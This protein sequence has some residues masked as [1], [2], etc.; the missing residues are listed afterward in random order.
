MMNMQKGFAIICFALLLLQCG[1][2]KQKNHTALR[3]PA[4][5]EQNS[6][7]LL[8]T[9][10]KEPNDGYSWRYRSDNYPKQSI[11]TIDKSVLLSTA[12]RMVRDRHLDIFLMFYS[13]DVFKMGS[14]DA[15]VAVVGQYQVLSKT[16][17]VLRP[18]AMDNR[19]QWIKDII[20]LVE[21]DMI[22]DFKKDPTNLRFQDALVLK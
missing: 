2:Q 4:V 8:S 17:V 14:A 18:S 9:Y 20:P 12:W 22:L 6:D 5:K 13:D 1:S 7:E 15:G 19:S 11:V 21:G 16:S 10:R 3:A